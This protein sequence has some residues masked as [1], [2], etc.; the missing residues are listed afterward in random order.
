MPFVHIQFFF[1]RENNFSIRFQSLKHKLHKTYLV[2]SMQ[3]QLLYICSTRI[4]SIPSNGYCCALYVCVCDRY[5]SCFLLGKKKQTVFPRLKLHYFL[6]FHISSLILC[7]VFVFNRPYG[8]LCNTIQY[9]EES[10]ISKV[11]VLFVF[12]LP[13]QPSRWTHTNRCHSLSLSLSRC[14]IFNDT[15]V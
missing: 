8:K 14:Y 13:V 6:F 9:I 1:E 12:F 7:S 10:V 4:I 15:F 3:L 2:H 5:W 11:W